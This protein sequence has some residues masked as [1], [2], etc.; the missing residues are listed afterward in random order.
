MSSQLEF[1]R[2][3]TLVLNYAGKRILMDP[4]FAKKGEYPGFPGT[5]NSEVRNPLVEMPV[6]PESLFDVDAVLVSHLHTDHWDPVAKQILPKNLKI[7]VQNE[8]DAKIVCSQGFTNVEALPEK[9]DFE[10]LKF[11]KTHCQ[12]GND[13][14]YSVPEMVE[15]L[16]KSSGF[17]FTTEGEK[18]VYFLGD[19]IWIEEV[20]N[21]LKSWIPDVVVV[22]AGHA[23]M[24]DE[25]FGAIIMGKE[26][27]ERIHELLPTA[28][29]IA[30][31]MEALNH[32][33]LS[34]RELR[35]FAEEK[36]F[37]EKLIIPK[38]GEVID[39]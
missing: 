5:V 13:M 7:L 14:A 36:G 16:G 26:D 18:S 35:R 1:I 17:Y 20:E 34:R 38:D 3:A 31:H 19:T 24:E 23:Q 29:I 22:N 21:N 9:A 33:I 30:I 15:F 39:F 37:S 8:D 2:N 32:C 4:M 12:H 25:R 27:L 28:T 11:T 10:G 6:K